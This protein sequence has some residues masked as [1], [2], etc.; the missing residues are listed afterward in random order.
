MTMTTNAVSNQFERQEAL[1]RLVGGRLTSVQ[2]ILSYLILGFDEKGSLTTLVWPEI[3]DGDEKIAFGT[4]GYRDKLCSLIEKT[5]KNVTMEPDETI[6]VDF[7]NGIEIR[8]PL[9]SY[10]DRGE[11]AILTGPKHYLFVF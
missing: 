2:F 6:S 3:L 10:Q 9:R 8:I 4:K 7:E 5:A 1:S 11:R